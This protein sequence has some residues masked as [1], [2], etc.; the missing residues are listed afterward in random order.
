MESVVHDTIIIGGG[1]AGLTAG[2]YA[3]RGGLKSLLVECFAPASQIVTADLIENYPGFPDGIDGFQLIERF[4]NQAKNFG[5]EFY[6]G[7][8]DNIILQDK[9][10]N[11]WQ[12]KTGDKFYHSLTVILAV[13]ARHRHLGVEG[14]EKF[15]GRGV[16][17]CAVCD[18]AFFKDKDIV[19]VG[20]GNSA[21]SEALYLT[22]FARKVILVHRRNRLRAVPVLAQRAKDNQ[23]I[24]F[25]W[26]SIITQIRGKDR[27]EGVDL[28]NLVDETTSYVS[29]GG[30]FISIGYVPNTD[31][32]AGLVELD[33]SGYVIT[34]QA[35]RT[36][37]SGVFACG[38]C[39]AKSLRQAVTACGDGAVAAFSAIEYVDR[40]KG[41]AYV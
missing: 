9:E 14:E 32:I 35:M 34:D 6:V 36:S 5:L 4:K 18:A 11:I 19:V 20:G 24:E 26:N 38:D 39:R 40:I 1:P 2:I 28:K 30:V 13:G 31:L 22:R 41:R 12:I 15:R 17:Y 10:K 29:C 16:S 33:D 37:R 23:K 25:I 21:V 27:V 3:S 7:K 8:V